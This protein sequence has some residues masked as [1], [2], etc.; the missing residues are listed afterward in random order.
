MNVKQKVFSIKEIQKIQSFAKE[1]GFDLFGYTEPYLKEEDYLYLEKFIEDKRYINMTWFSNY[2][3]IRLNPQKILENC[4]S[5]FVFGHYYKDLQYEEVLKNSKLKI[6]R[7]AIGKDYH[8]VLKKKL[9]LIENYL[10]QNFEEIHLRSTVDSAPVPEK[11]LAKY[12]GLGWQGK[13]T[14]IINLEYGSYFFLSCIFTDYEIPQ[15]EKKSIITD[16]C[17]GCTL[18]IKNCPTGALEPY[19]LNIEKC[20]SYLNIESK[21]PIPDKYLPYTKGWIFG[22]DICQEVCPFN[23]RKISYYKQTKETS[24]YLREEIKQILKELPEE[25]QWDQLFNSPLKR[26]KYSIF[27]ENYKK[28]KNYEYQ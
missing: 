22:C 19:K 13:N 12:A 14:N 23:R 4:K 17:K 25:K 28:I 18:C 10:K 9:K 21:E 16:H 24:F 6:S 15:E 7:Y 8:K 2:K 5:V 3:E 11:L 26:V 20:L 1:I 27:K